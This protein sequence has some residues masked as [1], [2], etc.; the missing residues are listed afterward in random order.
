M[1]PVYGQVQTGPATPSRGAGAGAVQRLGGRHALQRAATQS[2]AG[3]QYNTAP[4]GSKFSLNGSLPCHSGDS[5]WHEIDTKLR[6]M[7]QAL[8]EVGTKLVR[9]WYEGAPKVV[10]H[11]TNGT[12]LARGCAAVRHVLNNRTRPPP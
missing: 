8:Y 5:I 12:K 1:Y 6:K 2:C 10:R 11:I 3:L 4:M 7:V 9:S